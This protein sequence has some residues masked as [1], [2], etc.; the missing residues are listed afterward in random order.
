MNI[1]LKQAKRGGWKNFPLP[2]WRKKILKIVEKVIN[3]FSTT[4]SLYPDEGCNNTVYLEL[5]DFPELSLSIDRAE[6]LLE[7]G[8]EPRDLSSGEEADCLFMPGSTLCSTTRQLEGIFCCLT[9]HDKVIVGGGV[10]EGHRYTPTYGTYRKIASLTSEEVRKAFR[11]LLAE[12][13]ALQVEVLRAK[14]K[15]AFAK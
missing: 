4:V 12:Y 2:P 9:T 7:Q 8:E 5:Q 10:Q 6:K 13:V 11:E 14:E 3:P 15:R 1:L